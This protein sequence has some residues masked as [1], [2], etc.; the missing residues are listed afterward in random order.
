MLFYTNQFTQLR[1]AVYAYALCGIFVLVYI[2]VNLMCL[3]L[4]FKNKS[5][6]PCNIY[7]LI[8]RFYFLQEVEKLK[9]KLSENE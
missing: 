3:I 1:N 9:S 5:S 4:F 8:F 7:I 6:K 2:V